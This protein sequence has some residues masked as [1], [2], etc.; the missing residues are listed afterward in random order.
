VL[1]FARLFSGGQLKRLLGREAA[2]ELMDRCVALEFIR[3]YK[4]VGIAYIESLDIRFRN[5]CVWATRRR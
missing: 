1:Q 5:N 3:S 4:P 2:E